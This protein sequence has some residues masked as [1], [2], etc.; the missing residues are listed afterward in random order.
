[1]TEIS[2]EELLE[3]AENVYEAVVVMF[4]RARQV[5]DEQKMQIEME[6]ET[7]PSTDIKDNEDFDDV[8]IDREALMRE[9]KKYPK[10]SRV[11]IEEMKQGLIG[12]KYIE[13][14]E[15]EET[16]AVETG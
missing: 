13:P 11:A 6:M 3:K 15:E 8:E 5:N 9:H 16:G 7:L 12:Y 4:K 10:P 1:M 14:D 2:L